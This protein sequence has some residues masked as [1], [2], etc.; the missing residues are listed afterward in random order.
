MLRMETGLV[1]SKYVEVPCDSVTFSQRLFTPPA[2][3]TAQQKLATLQREKQQ[4]QWEKERIMTLPFRQAAYWT[5][6]G[7]R[8]LQ[9]MFSDE[10][11]VRLRVKDRRGYWKL[12]QNPAWALRE[13]KVLDDLVRHH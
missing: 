10:G 13:G 11:W 8:G 9:D 6:R 12:D 4:A 3:Q 1:R 5:R 2:R 7:F